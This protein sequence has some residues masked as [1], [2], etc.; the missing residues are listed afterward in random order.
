MLDTTLTQ[1]TSDIQIDDLGIEELS[2]NSSGMTVFGWFVGFR[3]SQGIY[4]TKDTE[5]DIYYFTNQSTLTQSQRCGLWDNTNKVWIQIY[6]TGTSYTFFGISANSENI[7]DLNYE[8]LAGSSSRLITI[9]AM[10]GGLQQMIHMRGVNKYLYAPVYTF[11][12]TPS[13]FVWIYGTPSGSA[14]LADSF[15]TEFELT[16][17]TILT[18]IYSPSTGSSNSYCWLAIKSQAE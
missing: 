8:S 11:D 4:Y 2:Y 15:N 12:G 14:S 7:V 1:I 16:D 10:G 17:G 3:S 18:P 5:N 6:G 9:P 13:K